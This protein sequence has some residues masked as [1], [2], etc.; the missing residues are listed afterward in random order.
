MRD[1]IFDHE[2]VENLN[3]TVERS[4]PRD[5]SQPLQRARPGKSVIN[6]N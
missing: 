5:A 1:W 3:H 2:E 4:V 6:T